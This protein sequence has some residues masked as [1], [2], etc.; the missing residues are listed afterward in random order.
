M[1]G[2]VIQA[3]FPGG[4]APLSL[5]AMVPPGSS[6]CLHCDN[7]VAQPPR[8]GSPP[9]AFRPATHAAPLQA[10]GATKSFAVD[11]HHLGLNRVGGRPLPS[12]VLAK[13]ETAFGSDFSAVRVH[14]GPQAARI[15]AL[16]FTIGTDIY[17]APGRYQP[18]TLHGQQILG[19]ELTHV[20]QQ[21]QGRVRAPAGGGL[22]VV[23]DH[24]LEAEADRLGQRAAMIA[25]RTPPP[26]KSGGCGGACGGKCGG[27]CGGNCKCG[28]SATAQ[29]LAPGGARFTG[30]TSLQLSSLKAIKRQQQ[31]AKEN[32][33]KEKHKPGQGKG[34]PE[35][36]AT[37][38]R[39]YQSDDCTGKHFECHSAHN[40][41]ETGS[42]W[43]YKN[44]SPCYSCDKVKSN[45]G[46]GKIAKLI[47]SG[48]KVK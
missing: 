25:I 41:C 48:S 17:F 31:R 10:H 18:E 37:V 43:E 33:E 46:N 32:E 7:R 28:K 42:S 15:G 16:A 39:C 2:R 23:Q 20:I 30:S 38:I 8:P 6:Q 26:A 12:T 29:P 40:C 45:E 4:Q 27:K 19:H 14:E 47:G 44:G 13:M 34:P 9:P 21:R 22:A 36:N 5:P 11:P 35:K 1:G 24:A 3:S